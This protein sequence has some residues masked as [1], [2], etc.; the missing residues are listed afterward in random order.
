MSRGH[1]GQTPTSEGFAFPGVSF[2]KEFVL[3]LSLFWAGPVQIHKS[4]AAPCGQK[5]HMGYTA[6]GASLH[7]LRNSF[8]CHKRSEME[9]VI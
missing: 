9:V 3:S 5:T 1:V 8:T 4:Q 7:T 6:Q 2:S